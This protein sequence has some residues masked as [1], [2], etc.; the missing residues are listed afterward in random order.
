LLSADCGFASSI[1]RSVLAP[2]KA[3]ALRIAEQFRRKYAGHPAAHA[4]IL[5]LAE[6]E[7]IYRVQKRGNRE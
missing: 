4:A 6:E 2:D 1:A 3:H 7:G 5:R